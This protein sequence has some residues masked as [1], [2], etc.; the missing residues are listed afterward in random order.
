MDFHTSIEAQK[1]ATSGEMWQNVKNPVTSQ[2]FNKWLRQMTAQQQID[3]EAIAGASLQAL[4]YRT[5]ISPGA[6]T[7]SK[8]YLEILEK[9]N[10]DKKLQARASA[11]DEDLEARLPQE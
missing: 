1:T 3:F 11:K 9:E 2:N 4:G 10:K 6:D 7:F 5:F 8:E